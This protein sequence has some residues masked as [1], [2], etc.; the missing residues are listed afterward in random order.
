M[1]LFPLIKLS[2]HSCSVHLHLIRKES[3]THM[4]GLAVYLKQGL[5]FERDL[6]SEN[7]VGSYTYFRLALLHSVSYPFFLYQSPSSS[8]CIDQRS[9][10]L[11]MCLP[12][13]GFNVHHKDWLTFS[14]GAD[15][16]GVIIL[17]SQLTLLRWLTFLLK[18]LTV[19]VKVLLF[20]IS[21]FLSSDTT[22]SFNMAFPHVS[23]MEIL[24]IML[25]S[26]FS[27]NFPQTQKATPLFMA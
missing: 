22:I 9:T 15:R 1:F 27:L 14:G 7:S 12:F 4:H 16:S 23:L 26:Q 10:H 11:L 21:F 8:L 20:W 17:L 25:L 6:Y 19:T 5:S 3:V 18:F 24:I 2:W 13:G